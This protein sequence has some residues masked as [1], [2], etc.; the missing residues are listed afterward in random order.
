MSIV[1]RARALHNDIGDLI[2]ASGG[3]YDPRPALQPAYAL[4]RV[5]AGM[6]IVADVN[7][8]I[9]IVTGPCRSPPSVFFH[10]AD[11]TFDDHAV[12][13]DPL[14]SRTTQDRACTHV[15]LTPVPWTSHR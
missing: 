1:S 13:F 2:S 3:R 12:R 5:D 14:C 8:I 15:V 6:G 4:A 10:A 9:V 7:C 11:F